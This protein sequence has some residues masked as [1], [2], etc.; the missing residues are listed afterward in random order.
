[1]TDVFPDAGIERSRAGERLRYEAGLSRPLPFL[2]VRSG[3]PLY[4]LVDNRR[5]KCYTAYSI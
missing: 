1:M 3:V 2:C 5:E 4:S